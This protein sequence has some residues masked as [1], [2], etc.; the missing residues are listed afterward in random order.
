MVEGRAGPVAVSLAEAGTVRLEVKSAH[1]V[2]D[3]ATVV[4][5]AQELVAR[6]RQ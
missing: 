2:V 5:A 6:Y 3:T 4:K 1:S